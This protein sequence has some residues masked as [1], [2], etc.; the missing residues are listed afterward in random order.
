MTDFDT[1]EKRFSEKIVQTELSMDPAHDLAHFQRVVRTAKNLARDENAQLEVVIPAAWLHDFVNLPKN[2]PDRKIASQL[3]SQKA[4]EYLGKIH[5][6]SV[7]FDGI[8][9]AI[10]AHSFSA[11]IQARTLEAQVVQD[12]DRLDALGAIGIARCFSVGGQ[13]KRAFY[14]LSDPF[15][16]KRNPDDGVFTVDHFFVKLLKLRDTFQTESGRREAERRTSFLRSYLE[17]LRTE[18]A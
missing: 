13:L 18:I 5:Y 14:E 7:W 2:H 3:S 12:A 4:V 10:E 11:A 6:P 1:W 16:Q 8:R 15:A 17:Q 9:H